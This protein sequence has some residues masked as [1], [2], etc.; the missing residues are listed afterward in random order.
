MKRAPTNLLISSKIVLPYSFL[1]S[2]LLLSHPAFILTQS[3]Y[4]L[5]SYSFS[6]FFMALFLLLVLSL[7]VP[8]TNAYWPPSPGYWPSSKFSS[9][10]FYKGFRNLWGPQHQRVDQNALTIWL[11][12]TSGLTEYYFTHIHTLTFCTLIFF[13]GWLSFWF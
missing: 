8:S 10:S 2:C 12:S 6:F 4:F 9:M 11:D 13:L 7:T 1:Q 5:H 3:F